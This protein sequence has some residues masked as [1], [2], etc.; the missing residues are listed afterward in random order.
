MA[1][2]AEGGLFWQTILAENA[3]QAALEELT[4]LSESLAKSE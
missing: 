4:T 2:S 1:V 3:L